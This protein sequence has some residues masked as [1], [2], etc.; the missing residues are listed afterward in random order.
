MPNITGW[1]NTAERTKYPFV[2]ACAEELRGGFI[3]I[4]ILVTPKVMG[5][6]LKDLNIE[7]SVISGSFWGQNT[8]KIVGI[9]SFDFSSL[10]DSCPITT[11]DGIGCGVLLF[12]R[13]SLLAE[14]KLVSR[15]FQA[16]ESLV[17]PACIIPLAGRAVRTIQFP[18]GTVRGRVALI[19]G[20]GVFLKKTAPSQVR[21]DCIGSAATSNACCEENAVPLRGINDAIPD[22]QG[23]IKLDLYPFSEPSSVTDV[24]QLLRINASPGTIT[25]S[26]AR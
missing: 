22:L 9:F 21:I 11:Q 23:N 12:D 3:D 25:I 17:H 13:S 15:S 20:D 2:E 8:G 14:P 24:V 5:V 4:H 26:L 19:E 7:G 16:S 18:E 6:F 1:N 10:S